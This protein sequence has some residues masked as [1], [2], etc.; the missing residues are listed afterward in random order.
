MATVKKQ[1]IRIQKVSAQLELGKPT[2]Q[3][4]LNNH[5]TAQGCN[6]GKTIA[7]NFSKAGWSWGCVA[8]V[9]SNGLTIFVA[10]AHRDDGRRFIVQS[11][12][13]LSAFVE[14]EREVLT[15]TFYL[16]SV[17]ASSYR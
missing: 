12:D 7:Y 2:P 1:A 8:T 13:K 14:P 15:V 11:D 3:I 16:E 5:Q 10:D 4:A 17:H 6:I 9:D